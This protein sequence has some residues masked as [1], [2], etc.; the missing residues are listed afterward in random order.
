MIIRVRVFAD[1][2]YFCKIYTLGGIYDFSL[3]E[4]Q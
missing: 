2:N 1:T 3:S 4:Y